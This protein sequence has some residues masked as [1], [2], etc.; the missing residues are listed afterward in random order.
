MVIQEIN[1]DV[2]RDL[3]ATALGKRSLW[4][5]MHGLERVNFN[6]LTK[7]LKEFGVHVDV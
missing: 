6:Q 1:I 2:P 3:V 7:R 5:T 4:Q